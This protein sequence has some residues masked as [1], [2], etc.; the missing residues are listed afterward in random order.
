LTARRV[1]YIRKAALLLY[2]VALP[3]LSNM[4]DALVQ[5]NTFGLEETRNAPDCRDR[6]VGGVLCP[7]PQKSI[8]QKI[9]G[10]NSWKDDTD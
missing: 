9:E 2:V 10:R 3:M 5:R 1:R 7:T 4:R 8:V 6:F